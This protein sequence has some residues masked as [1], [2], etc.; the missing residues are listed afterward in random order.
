MAALLSGGKDS[1]YAIYI[2]QQ[3]GWSVSPAVAL[4]PKNRSWMF[5]GVNSHLIPLIAKNIGITLLQKI[6]L[7]EKEKE[8]EDLKSILSS[9][10]VDGVISGAIAS[11]YQ[12][13][14][15]EEVCH[16]LKIKSFMPLWHKNQEQLLWDMLYNGFKIMVVATAA[17]GLGEKWLG[18]IIDATCISTFVKLHKKY[19][20]N[21][22]GEGGE[23]ETLVLDCPLFSKPFIVDEAEKIWKRDN[24]ICFVK[25][26]RTE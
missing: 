15:I 24:G 23:F 8:L 12:R 10:K 18:K 19:G 9:T 21:I 7:G 5:H 20:L 17:E 16:Q 2:A 3:Y 25:K 11:E 13:T 1:I 22:A 6:T 4:L 26:I 14:R